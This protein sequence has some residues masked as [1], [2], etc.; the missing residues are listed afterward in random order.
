M[1]TIANASVFYEKFGISARISYQ[2][3]SDYLDTV[4]GLGIGE[5]ESRGA[6]ESLDVSLRYQITENFAVFADLANL[7]DEI[8][9]AL[10]RT[11]D[12]AVEVEQI[13]SRYLFGV[14]LDF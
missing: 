7:T 12:F 10:D 2:W 5:G 14:R 8:Y 11:D 3:R 9:T 4:G 13:G 6:Y 1:D